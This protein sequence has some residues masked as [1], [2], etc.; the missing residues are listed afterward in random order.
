[1]VTKPIDGLRLKGV[2]HYDE[3]F[4]YFRNYKDRIIFGG[5]RNLD[6]ENEESFQFRYNFKIIDDL[7]NKLVN[8]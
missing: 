8:R 6:F 4:Y 7:E 1:L 2:F 3:G 5:G